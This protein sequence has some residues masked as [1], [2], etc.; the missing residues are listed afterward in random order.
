MSEQNSNRKID[1]NL[2]LGEHFGFG[3]EALERDLMPYASSVNIAAGAHAGDAFI[4]DQSLSL[5]KEYPDLCVGALVSYP[6]IIGFGARRIQLSNEELRASIIHQLGGLMQLAKL[7]NFELK[8]VRFHGH[9]YQQM[10]TNYSL[11]ETVIKAIKDV[12]Q[13]LIIVSPNSSIVKDVCGWLNMQASFEARIDLRY[14]AEN[15]LIPFDYNHDGNLA[16]DVISERAKNLIFHSKIK[17]IQNQESN[18]DFET[19]HLPATLKN[20][21][22]IAKFMH[23]MVPNIASLKQFDYEPYLPEFL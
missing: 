23:G 3:R 14:N 19:I 8:H 10:Y 9:L 11:V 7:H 12:S 6:D 4:M 22:D 15:Q 13:W 16:L 2:N 18:I 21:I 1:L 17:N 5:A 20:S